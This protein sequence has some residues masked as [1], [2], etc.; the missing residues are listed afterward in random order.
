MGICFSLCFPSHVHHIALRH[1]STV[2][3]QHM[4]LE[5]AWPGPPHQKEALKSTDLAQLCL[6]LQPLQEE[7]MVLLVGQL[8]LH[9]PGAGGQ[10]LRAGPS[11]GLV[12]SRH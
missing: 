11:Q 8:L 1:N 2:L 9:S 12:G 6:L 10:G 4:E 7:G 5:Y 3:P